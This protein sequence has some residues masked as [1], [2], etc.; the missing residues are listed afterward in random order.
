MCDS[1]Y[2]KLY[3]KEVKKLK[4]IDELVD[5]YLQ[6]D[7]E[8]LYVLNCQTGEILLDAD[9]SLTGE[10]GIDWDDEEATEFLVEIPQISSN[11]AYDVMV[12]FTN[13]QN[14]DHVVRLLDILNG[15]KPFRFFKEKVNELGI[16]EQWHAFEYECAKSRMEEWL[17]GY[18]KNLT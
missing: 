17:E 15:R 18:A 9:E 3:L 2:L 1:S 4:V 10:P 12:Q 13:K 8:I 6:G 16:E 7:N 14:A 11:E 5:A